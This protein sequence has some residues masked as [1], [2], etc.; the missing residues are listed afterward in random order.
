M[1]GTTPV[2]LPPAPLPVSLLDQVVI[3]FHKPQDPVNIAGTVRAMKNMG[4]SQLRLVD[5][6]AYDPWRIEGI[7]HGTRDI[8]ARIRHFDTL[9]E[10]LA[11]CVRVHGYAG[12]PR[13]ARWA[14]LDPAGS[15]EELLQFAPQGPVALLFG[16]EDHGLDNDALDRAHA[17]VT[18]PTTEHASLNLAQAVLLACYELHRQAGDATRRLRRP[19]HHAPPATARQYEQTFDVWDRALQSI[20]FYKTRNPQLVMRAFRSLTFRSAPDGRETDLLRAIGIEVLR[21]VDRLQGIYRGGY[22]KPPGT[23]DA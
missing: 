9:D 21:T 15:A 2:R 6:V 3:V 13:A 19:R 20:D 14:R 4:V 1:P 12:K 16:P 11:D 17:T 23:P 7:A 5:P 10:A 22:G 18:I 8:V